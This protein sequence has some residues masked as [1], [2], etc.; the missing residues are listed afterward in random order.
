[1]VENTENELF[2]LYIYNPDIIHKNWYFHDYD[3]TDCKEAAAAK[4]LSVSY[5]VL[6][7]GNPAGVP[8]IIDNQE[9]QFFLAMVD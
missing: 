8:D 6:P 3:T 9:N 5:R 2:F 1:M 4:A 7:Q